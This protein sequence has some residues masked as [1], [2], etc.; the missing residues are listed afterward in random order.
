M[1]LTILHQGLFVALMSHLGFPGGNPAFD[2]SQMT[3]GV[4][5]TTCDGPLAQGLGLNLFRQ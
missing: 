1:R 2:G 5:G 3:G 4:T